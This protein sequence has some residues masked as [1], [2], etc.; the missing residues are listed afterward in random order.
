MKRLNIH[1]I[2]HAHFEN[3]G[4]IAEWVKE[5]NYQLNSTRIWLNEPFSD[6]ESI[7]GLIIMGGPMSVNDEEQYPWLKREKQF[8]AQVIRDKKPVL[9]ICLGAQLIA[10]VLGAQVFKAPQKEIGWWTITTFPS[11]YWETKGTL[12]TFL[13]HGETFTLP[14]GATL[15][16]SSEAIAHQG[17]SYGEKVVGIQFHP[18][19]TPDGIKNLI[20][21]CSSDLSIGNFIQPTNAMLSNKDF[22]EEN[23]KLLFTLLEKLFG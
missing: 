4:S 21:H 11:N 19:V 2:K 5:K 14:E 17:F 9:G 1:C 22:Y 10:N 12:T 13:W 6:S 18:E 20:Q 7:D 8:I 15:L 3:E 16:A 23:K